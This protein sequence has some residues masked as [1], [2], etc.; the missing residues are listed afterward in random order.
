MMEAYEVALAVAGSG[1]S[2]GGISWAVQKVKIAALEER[3]SEL[4]REQKIIS[5]RSIRNESK[6]DEVLKTL[7]RFERYFNRLLGRESED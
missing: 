7:D 2:G 6:F 3:V 5:D 4:E 1:L